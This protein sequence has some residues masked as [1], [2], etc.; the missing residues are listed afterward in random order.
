MHNTPLS[1]EPVIFRPTGSKIFPYATRE[2]RRWIV[3]RLNDFPE[4]PLYTLFVDAQ[5][6]DDFD[7]APDNWLLPDPGAPS[8]LSA[9]EREEALRTVSGLEAYG[10]ETGTP[11]RGEFCSCSQRR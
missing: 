6:V 5:H 4:H 3:L 7:D 1:A 9:R 2:A 10:A 8:V 11:C